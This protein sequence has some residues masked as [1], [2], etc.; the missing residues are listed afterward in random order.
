MPARLSHGVDHVSERQAAGRAAAGCSVISFGKC[1]LL[2]SL[3]LPCLPEIL[4]FAN[5]LC[6]VFPRNGARVNRCCELGVT[7]ALVIDIVS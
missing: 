4:N 1:K 2:I 5:V 7:P 3:A 6:S